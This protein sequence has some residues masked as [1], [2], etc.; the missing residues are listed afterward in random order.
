MLAGSGHY[1]H[2]ITLHRHSTAPHHTQ[3]E[4]PCR[5]PCRPTSTCAAPPLTASCYTY[6]QALPASP[7][8]SHSVPNLPVTLPRFH[9]NQPTG[10][11]RTSRPL[12]S[13]HPS[14]TR[15]RS[16]SNLR[17]S[18]SSACVTNGHVAA[19]QRERAKPC[20]FKRVNLTGQG[21]GLC[22]QAVT[23]RQTWHIAA[24]AC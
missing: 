15:M 11:Q 3:P 8:R 14:P 20:P 23:V 7:R 4:P 1:S 21:M 19:W 16:S 24:W 13:P 18:S 2:R 6:L 10:T 5:T 12:P 9:P 17:R 22:V